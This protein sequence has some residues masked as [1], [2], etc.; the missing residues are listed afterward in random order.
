LGKVFLDVVVEIF[1]VHLYAAAAAAAAAVRKVDPAQ[2][3]L[4]FRF[5]DAVVDIESRRL[6]AVKSGRPRGC[7][8]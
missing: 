5:D 4:K 2:G 7:R 6:G 3:T 1:H 8:G